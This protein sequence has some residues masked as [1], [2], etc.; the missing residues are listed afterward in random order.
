MSL[1]GI[2]DVLSE[3]FIITM[4]NS[5]FI[6]LYVDNFVNN[7]QTFQINDARQLPVVI[8][9]KKEK[10]KAKS[11]LSEAIQSKKDLS[12]CASLDKIQ[13]EVDRLIYQVFH[14]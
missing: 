12:F 11:L 7:T 2:S 8:P 14:L 1:F 9:T 10:E 6:S 3:D 13:E 5:T 4:M